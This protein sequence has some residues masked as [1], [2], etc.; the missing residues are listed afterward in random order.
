MECGGQMVLV[1]W[2]YAKKKEE[3][4]LQAASGGLLGGERGSRNV[5]FVPH[6]PPAAGREEPDRHDT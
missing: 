1:G 5:Q 2:R 4:A 3:G 6:R